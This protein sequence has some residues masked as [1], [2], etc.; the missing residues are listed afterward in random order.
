MMKRKGHM[1]W[2]EDHEGKVGG[3]WNK[4]HVE[5]RSGQSYEGYFR[6]ENLKLSKQKAISGKHCMTKEEALACSP[7]ILGCVH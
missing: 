6:K 7:A 4:L 3:I 5:T 1:K 2:G